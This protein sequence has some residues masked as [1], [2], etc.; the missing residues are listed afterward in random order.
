MLGKVTYHKVDDA[1]LHISI[2]GEEQLLPVDNVVIC[3]GQTSQRTLAD[4]LQEAGM[5]VHI[6]GGAYEA[7]E[8][9]AKVA[10][11]QASELAAAI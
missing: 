1:G 8:I 7:R 9:D 10:I 5:N 4:E 11:K 2:D 3:A 6:I